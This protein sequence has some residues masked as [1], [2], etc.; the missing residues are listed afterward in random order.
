MIIN[1]LGIANYF[2]IVPVY[3]IPENLD[4]ENILSLISVGGYW[5]SAKGKEEL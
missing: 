1:S 3:S 5:L 2:R 4:F